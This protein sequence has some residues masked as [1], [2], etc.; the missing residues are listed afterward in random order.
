MNGLR[1]TC[2]KALDFAKLIIAV[3]RVKEKRAIEHCLDTI[4]DQLQ[5]ANQI[6]YIVVRIS[7]VFSC[8]ANVASTDWIRSLWIG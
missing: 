6:N 8:I 3:K 1:E 2:K 7:L 4:V 5:L